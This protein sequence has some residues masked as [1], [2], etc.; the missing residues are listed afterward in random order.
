[1]PSDWENTLDSMLWHELLWPFIGVKKLHVGSSLTLQLS[2]AL[3]STAVDL[4]SELL[5]DL[6]EL[7]VQLEIGHAY[8][9]FSLFVETRESVGRPVRLLAPPILHAEQEELHGETEAPR[10]DPEVHRKDTKALL[11]YF[12]GPY[13]NRAMKL[14]SICRTFIQAQNQVFRAYDE[15]RR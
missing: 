5:P 7:E 4:V 12:G 9:L 1:M 2:H 10:A 11:E 6:Q 3:Q 14:I 15:L 8:N 13:R